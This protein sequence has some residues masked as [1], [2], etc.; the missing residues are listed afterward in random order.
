MIGATRARPALT[1]RSTSSLREGDILLSSDGHP[2]AGYYIAVREAG[3]GYYEIIG[4]AEKSKNSVLCAG[5]FARILH[6]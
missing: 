2:G 5:D 6:G 4:F 3:T 1:I